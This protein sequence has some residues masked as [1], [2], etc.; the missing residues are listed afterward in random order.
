LAV[1][2]ADV[3]GMMF[4]DDEDTDGDTDTS[5]GY[6]PDNDV[7]LEDP[8]ADGGNGPDTGGSVGSEAG[9]GEAGSGQVTVDPNEVMGALDSLKDD[10][11]EAS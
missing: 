1:K 2:G 11:P 9:D 6:D 8:T 5:T 10:S 4:P 3:T 7:D